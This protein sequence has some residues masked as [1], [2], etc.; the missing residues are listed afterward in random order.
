MQ[1]SFPGTVSDSLG[2]NSLAMQTG[3]CSSCP[4]DR[5]Q[6]IAEVKILNVEVLEWMINKG[7]VLTQIYADYC[8]Q[9][10]TEMGLLR[11][12]GNSQI[13]EFT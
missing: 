4:G 1:T 10:L 8:E 11:T 9:Y 5:C 2:G 6:T 7:G 12:D 3:C 13:F